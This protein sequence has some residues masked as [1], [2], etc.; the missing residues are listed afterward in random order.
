MG[1]LL[2]LSLLICKIGITIMSTSV[3]L[4][5]LNEKVYTSYCGQCLASINYLLTTIV[6]TLLLLVVV[7]YT[8][9]N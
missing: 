7:V 6:F 9:K 3:L 8:I 1:Q 5:R 2:N 4:G